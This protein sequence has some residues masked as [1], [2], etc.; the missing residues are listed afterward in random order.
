MQERYLL[1]EILAD[2]AGG[3]NIV[4]T[5]FIE[6][7]AMFKADGPEAYRCVGETEFVN[8]IAAMSASGSY[9]KS[10]SPP[11]SSARS[12][13]GSAM[14]RP[15]SWMRISR[16]AAAG[17]AASGAAPSGTKSPDIQNHRTNPPEGLL[18]RDDFR[19]GF[20][21]LGPR[22]LSFEVWCAHTQMPDAISLARAFPDTTHRSRPF[23]RSDRHRALCRQ[24]GRGVRR[25]E[26]ADRRAGAL[27]ECGRQ[28]WRAEHGG[29]RVRLGAPSLAP[30]QH[31]AGARRRA[32]TSSTRSIAS[33]PIAACSSRTSRSTS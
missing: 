22:K 33:A 7:G 28:A 20:K 14:R 11:A 23:R 2:V 3:H 27:P 9:G 8:G 5:V 29:Q 30:D 15:A 21:H 13:C 12:I 24:A 10:G 6:C 25:L 17:F 19:A 4:S 1:D 16:P 18:L 31:R 26:D 32:A